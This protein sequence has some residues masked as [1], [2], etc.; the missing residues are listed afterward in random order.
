MKKKIKNKKPKAKYILQVEKRNE[1]QFLGFVEINELLVYA[2]LIQKY[3][4]TFKTIVYDWNEDLKWVDRIYPLICIINGSDSLELNA[5]LSG[6]C[7][8]KKTKE[9]ES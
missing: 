5:K 2:R 9:T 4:P 8:P 7:K 3:K 6:Y 1:C